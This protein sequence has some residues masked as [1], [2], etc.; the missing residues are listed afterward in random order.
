MEKINVRPVFCAFQHEYYFEGPC[1][2][3]AGD[4]LKPEFDTMMN[5]QGYISFQ[6]ELKENI[7]EDAVNLMEPIYVET[8]DSWLLSDELFETIAQDVEQVDLYIFAAGIGS[9][10]ILP[11][12]AMRYHKPITVR[13][14][15]CCMVTTIGATLFSRGCEFIPS[16]T[17][18]ELRM[19]MRA[20]KTKKALEKTTVL[21]GIRFDSGAKNTLDTFVSNETVTKKL[22]VHFRSFNI[23]EFMDELHP[24]TEEGNYTTPGRTNTP[25]ITEEDIA[26]A[27]KMAKELV[28]GASDVDVENKFLV[29]SLK[30]YLL[31]KKNLDHYGANAFSLPC[32]DLCSTRRI[33]KEQ[34]TFCLSHSLLNEEG[35][36]S[37]CD[38]DLNAL[39]SMTALIAVSGN[40][41]F[42]GNTNPLPVVNGEIKPFAHFD[43]DSTKELDDITNLY[44]TNH[45]V[46]S[47]KFKGIAGSCSAYGIRHF[48]HDQ[49]FGAVLRYD[50]NQDKDQVITLL[51]FSPDLKKMLV[52]KGTIVNGGGY[53][54]NNC[55]GFVN[56]RVEDQK[57]FFE[58]H[59]QVGMHLPFV[60]GDFTEELSELG[61]MLD[62]EVMRV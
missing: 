35:I 42:M 59:C 50:F 22:G 43:A 29:N 36:P 51:R 41:P 15:E 38:S 33:N 9:M 5:Q 23:H 52:G 37:A 2:F 25:N 20:M 57:K 56:Y 13:P 1:R 47:R 48:A 40:A 24:I 18:D 46:P 28:A 12:F 60:Y 3:G 16:L 62:I 10:Q 55:N 7:P 45:S 21:Y 19:K 8:T 32:P 30:G 39:I 17:W 53:D 14:T 58:A 11:E 49:G 26:E 61:K 4:A 27:E 6:D 44:N 34:L 31:V 54:L